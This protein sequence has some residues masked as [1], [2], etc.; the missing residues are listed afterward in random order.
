MK[1]IIDAN[2]NTTE[3]RE[4]FR[5]S[6]AHI[7]AMAV[8]SL[9]P[10][11]KIAI[12]PALE[13]GFYY[14]VDVPE[15]ITPEILEKIEK[16]MNELIEQDIPF[17]R[18]EIS[19]E[20]AIELFTKRNETYKVEI[21]KSLPSETVSIYKNH[22]FIDLCRGPHLPSTGK[23][24]AVKLLNVSGAYWRGNE[25]NPMLQRIYGTCFDS[26]KNL[27]NYLRVLEEAKKR[28][29]RKLGK[30]L[31]LFSFHEEGPGLPF[32]LPKGMALK[33]SLIDFWREEHRKAGY[34][35]LQTPL[36][37]RQKLW[38][39]SGHLENYR[40][41][42]YLTQIDEEGYVIKP[43]N[44]P[45]SMLV[46]K[47]TLHSYRDLPLRLCEL[48]HVHR[49]ERSGVLQGLFRVRSFTQ[50]DA[51]I[52]VTEDQIK[53]EIL[54]I[55]RLIDRF[56]KLFG[57]EYEVDISTK[58]EKYIGSD[59]LWEKATSALEDA[60]KEF[61]ISYNLMPGAGAFYGPKIDFQLI[62]SLGRPHQCATVQLDMNLPER[63]DL[64]YRGQDGKDHKPVVLHRVIYGSLERF[65]G[66]LIEH[67]G[68][69]FPL[70]LAPIQARVLS[71][72][73]SCVDYAGELQQALLQAGIRSECD[74]REEK[75]GLKIRES[76]KEKIPYMVVVG[77]KEKEEKSLSLRRHKI[78]DQGKSSLD[79]FIQKLK[80]E[81]NNKVLPEMEKLEFQKRS[82]KDRELATRDY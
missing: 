77:E 71:I 73:Q 12:G 22:D 79:E 13:N 76:E 18:E 24:K 78:G 74:L 50:D 3:G 20:K 68:G 6:T 46:Y 2:F 52:F 81:I 31:R 11:A 32:W 15:Q 35:E 45:G 7:M 39:T 9:Y 4:V 29:H 57:F 61:G 40:E 58:P 80:Q 33:N 63:F 55:V 72:N 75:I 1:G 19:K 25:N 54:E 43:M 47:E 8:K 30:E 42:M 27:R 70:W 65:L 10:S 5:H 41:N 38:E 66:I 36:I 23:V 67:F 51:H 17:E 64:K 37:L 82:T 59:A 49:H 44:C 53:D 28:D 21:I 69:D 60:L 26:D 16:R 14:D 56:Y 34:Q 48:G 62:D